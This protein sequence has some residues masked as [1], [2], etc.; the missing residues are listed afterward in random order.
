[1]IYAPGYGADT[2][3]GFAAGA[4]SED[5]INLGAFQTSAHSRTSLRAQRKSAATR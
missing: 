1:M 5:K 3:F 2:I 4:G